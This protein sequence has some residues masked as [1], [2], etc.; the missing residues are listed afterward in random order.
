MPGPLLVLPLGPL[1]WAHLAHL[2]HLGEALRYTELNPARVVMVA[3]ADSYPRSSAAVH[4]G[5]AP[6]DVSLD[7]RLWEPSWTTGDWWIYLRGGNLASRGP[8]RQQPY[9]AAARH[10]GIYPEAGTRLPPRPCCSERRSPAQSCQRLTVINSQFLVKTSPLSPVFN[11]RTQKGGARYRCLLF[12]RRR[13]VV[14][15]NLG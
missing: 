7:T 9:R 10:A 5:T 2:A 6:P 13:S 8:S 11:L 12:P 14:G 4:C 3:A 1:G 15:P